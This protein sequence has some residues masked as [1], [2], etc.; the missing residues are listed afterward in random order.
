MKEKF[1]FVL[2]SRD[3]VGYR[4][5]P[6]LVVDQHNLTV[7]RALFTALIWLSPDLQRCLLAP[8]GDVYSS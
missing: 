1:V 8:V 4:I 3:L 5:L 6:S 7:H 2:P